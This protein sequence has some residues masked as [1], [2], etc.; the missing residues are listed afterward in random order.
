[1]SR[2]ATWVVN[3]C[4]KFELDTTVGILC[5]VLFYITLYSLEKTAYSLSYVV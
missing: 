4:T 5:A 3:P 2:D 1:M